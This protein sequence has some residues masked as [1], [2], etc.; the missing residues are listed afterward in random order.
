MSSL[1]FFFGG[2]GDARHVFASIIDFYEK[3][4]PLPLEK[5]NKIRAQFVLNDIKA[6]PLAKQLIIFSAL[7]KLAEFKYE[8]IGVDYEATKAAALVM[9]I[10]I[11]NVMPSY[12]DAEMKSIIKNLVE[13]G[14]SDTFWSFMK[15]DEASWAETKKV[16]EQWLTPPPITTKKMVQ[17]WSKNKLD[18]ASEILNNTNVSS[19]LKSELD[20]SAKDFKRKFLEALDQTEDNGINKDEFKKMLEHF[21]PVDLMNFQSSV[22][23]MDKVDKHTYIENEFINQCKF[24]IPPLLIQSKEEKSIC[25]EFLKIRSVLMKKMSKASQSNVNE[26]IHDEKRDMRFA[27]LSVKLDKFVN[28]SWKQNVTMLDYDWFNKTGEECIALSWS[29]NDVANSLYKNLNQEPANKSTLFDWYAFYFHLLAKAFKYLAV[30]TSCLAVEGRAGDVNNAISCCH[31]EAK[32]RALESGTHVDLFKFNRIYL[33]NIPDYTSMIYAFLECGQMLKSNSNNSFFKCTVMM[34]TGIWKDYEH[35]V[36][37]TS[38]IKSLKEC[39][40]LLNFTTIAGDLWGSDPIWAHASNQFKPS[41]SSR[42]EVLDWLSRVLLNYAYP[43]K[44]DPRAA[45][46]ETQAPSLVVFF[47]AIQYLVALGFPKHWFQ[48][49]LESILE[50]KFVTSETAPSISPN[51]YVAKSKSNKKLCHIDLSP[52]LLEIQMITGIFA[53]I[54]S[55]GNFASAKSADKLFEYHIRFDSFNDGRYRIVYN[56][57]LPYSNVLGL[58][59]EEKIENDGETCMPFFLPFHDWTKSKLRDLIMSKNSSKKAHLF[60]VMDFC[61]KTK[62]ARFWMSKR[63]FITMKSK[64]YVSLIR[65]DSWDRLTAPTRL[66]KANESIKYL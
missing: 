66:Q 40:S 29:Y 38:L 45:M 57:T 49:Y 4:L 63:D 35:Y 34:N 51:A 39:S 62:T 16:L 32:R 14:L 13:N 64:W 50:N 65:T 33:S 15:I 20:D 22:G 8:Q 10:F 37:S 24:F 9:Y 43:C 36:Y 44:R 46:R 47:K 11:C 42:Q 56:C 55:I 6:H 12:L 18:K 53:P 17:L 1:R 26:D 7:R 60:S 61:S 54:L 3:L 41:L 19:S 25:D 2:F 27:E 31:V 48:A 52:I 58:L 28:K 23:I 59:F 21:S 5:Q 30:D